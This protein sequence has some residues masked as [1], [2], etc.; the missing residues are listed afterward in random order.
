MKQPCGH[1]KTLTGHRGVLGW[2]NATL[3]HDV[4][5]QNGHVYLN[6]FVRFDRVFPLAGYEMRV[7]GPL[8][9]KAGR[10]NAEN[11][12]V[13]PSDDNPISPALPVSSVHY[14]LAVEGSSDYRSLEVIDDIAAHESGRHTREKPIR[15]E[16]Q[17]VIPRQDRVRRLTEG[18]VAFVTG[19]LDQTFVF[20]GQ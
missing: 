16:R 1:A 12:H 5:G 18:G 8:K 11:L 19:L 13:V 2:E 4:L 17:E 14:V 3:F 7:S 6:T 10:G 9:G 15:N 20:V